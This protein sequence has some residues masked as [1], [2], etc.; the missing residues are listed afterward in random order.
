MC[1]GNAALPRVAAGPLLAAGGAG[2]AAGEQGCQPGTLP[3]AQL[4]VV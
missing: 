4:Q 1:E 2:G 3:A